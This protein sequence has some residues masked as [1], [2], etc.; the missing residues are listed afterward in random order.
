MKKWYLFLWLILPACKEKYMPD[1]HVPAS[2]FL[3]VEGF[4]NAGNGP[5]SIQLSRTTGLDS[6]YILPEAGAQVE[7]QGENGASYPLTEQG[8]GK[9]SVNQ[10]TIDPGQRYR[11]H[12]KTS[13][14]KEYLSDLTEVKITPPIDSVSWKAGSDDLGVF[15]STHDDEKKSV[16][17]QWEFQETWQ[18]NTILKSDYIRSAPGEITNRTAEESFPPFCWSYDASENIMISSS[19]KLSEDVIHEFPLTRISYSTTNKLNTRYSILVKQRVLTKEWFEWKDRVKKNT[20]KLGSIF[21]PLPSGITG[22]IH[23]ITDPTETV[24]GFIGCTTEVEK[25]IFISHSD[26][27]NVNI[28]TGYEDCITSD[29][30]YY[31]EKTDNLLTGTGTVIT[32]LQVNA[33]VI[34]GVT[35]SNIDCV[36]CRLKGGTATK[37]DFW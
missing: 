14:G 35:I 6:I 19:A 23:S 20:E 10:L 25:R 4:I 31:T 27:P 22:N 18:Y 29:L 36:D 12:I 7:V 32:G 21:D 3:V 15:V 34:T 11:L 5:T 1:I 17:Y 16:Y 9:Y 33:G 28:Y 37:P 2:G 30:P 13:N 26:I 8:S 24:I